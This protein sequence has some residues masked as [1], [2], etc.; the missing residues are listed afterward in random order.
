MITLPTTDIGWNEANTESTESPIIALFGCSEPE[1][2]WIMRL[3]T[4]LPEI[5]RSVFL[6]GRA[7]P[8]AVSFRAHDR[9]VE[10]A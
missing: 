2:A 1:T 6:L 7:L 8:V 10:G 9:L 3:E 4:D 5:G